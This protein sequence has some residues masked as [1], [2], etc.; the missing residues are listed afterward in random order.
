MSDDDA[1]EQRDLA[2]LKNAND[3]LRQHIN[4]QLQ[5]EFVASVAQN[6][7]VPDYLNGFDWRDLFFKLC[8]EQMLQYLP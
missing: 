1:I 6:T 8:F 5:S 7:I 2:T 3:K 4:R